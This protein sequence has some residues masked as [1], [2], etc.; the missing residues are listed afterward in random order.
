MD[1]ATETK[2]NR[3][4]VK[5][6][7]YLIGRRRNTIVAMNEIYLHQQLTTIVNFN[8]QCPLYS[9]VK[10]LPNF[11]ISSLG[12]PRAFRFLERQKIARKESVKDKKIGVK[13]SGKTI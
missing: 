10:T 13:I 9:L 4:I 2:L 11:F 7:Y 6:S 5:K 1:I 3:T 12:R 8:F